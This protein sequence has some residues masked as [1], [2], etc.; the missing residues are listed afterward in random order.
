MS[1]AE[2]IEL[3]I[4]FGANAISTFTLFISMTFA[5]LTL[6]HFVGAT[7][8]RFQSISISIVYV[9][10]ASAPAASAY[11]HM[12]AIQKL[13][14]KYPSLLDTVPGFHME[15]WLIW[16]PIMTLF[17]LGLSLYFMYEVRRNSSSA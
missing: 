14:S 8:S 11:T 15:P 4:G 17:I 12:A 5:Y 10:G 7:L 1:E 2:V 3:T 6:C 16:E 9:I 13:Q